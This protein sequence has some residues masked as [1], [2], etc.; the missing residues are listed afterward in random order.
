MTNLNF[1]KIST[2]IVKAVGS[3]WMFA[4]FL[5]IVLVWFIAGFFMKWNTDH[6]L[7]IS[8]IGTPV[9]LLLLFIIQQSQ[10][11]DTL[12]LHIKM[13]EL[14]KAMQD[15]DSELSGIEEKS[16]KELKKLKQEKQ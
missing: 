16:E 9:S 8:N 11:K 2:A 5:V 6:A 10:N 14:V 13:N 4:V 12:A 1:D 3:A 15:A 7:I